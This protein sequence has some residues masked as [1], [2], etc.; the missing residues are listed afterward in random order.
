[1]KWRGERSEEFLAAHMARDQHYRGALAL[2]KDGMILALR[3]QSLGNI[4]ATRSAPR[5]SFRSRWW[6]RW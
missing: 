2:D 5:R 6:R 3:M 1:V 4:G